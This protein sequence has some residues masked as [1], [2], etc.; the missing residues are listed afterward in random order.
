VIT[1][2][3]GHTLGWAVLVLGWAVTFLGSVWIIVLRWQRSV[4]RG[5]GVGCFLFP[6]VQLAYVGLHWE[7]AKGCFFMLL[8]GFALT[9][10]GHA[11]G[12]GN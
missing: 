10:L 3:F 1:T 11:M 2:F 8:A 5:V 12:V 4:L 7:E 9:I 6:V